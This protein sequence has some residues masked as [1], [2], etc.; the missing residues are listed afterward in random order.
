MVATDSNDS[1]FVTCLVLLSWPD[2][3]SE[4]YSVLDTELINI[5]FRM[6]SMFAFCFAST[7]S[8]ASTGVFVG[9][10][11]SSESKQALRHDR[12]SDVCE[13]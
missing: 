10:G 12:K 6:K 1:P 8:F 7:A 5:C 3:A 2:R 11:L 4:I 13:T 9:E